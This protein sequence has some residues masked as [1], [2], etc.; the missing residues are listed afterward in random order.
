MSQK[1]GVIAFPK[2]WERKLQRIRKQTPFRFDPIPSALCEYWLTELQ[3]PHLRCL[4]YICRRTWG[5]RKEWD[6][7]AIDHFV[8]GIKTRDGKAVDVGVGYGETCVR[9]TLRDLEKRGFIEI[10][11]RKTKANL[12]RL[13]IKPGFAESEPQN[14]AEPV[15][16]VR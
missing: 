7:I 13:T 4:I 15:V 10:Q 8:H 12:Y 16:G 3:L 1:S 14:S 9:A 6:A 11:R 2:K 5:Y